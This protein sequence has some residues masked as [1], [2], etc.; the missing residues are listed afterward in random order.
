M[1]SQLVYLFDPETGIYTNYYVAQESPLEPG[2]FI[3]PVYSTP[4]VP[5]PAVQGKVPVFAGGAWSLVVDYR[6]QTWYDQTTGDPVQITAIGQPAA[7]LAATPLPPP[8]PTPTVAPPPPTAAQLL[9]QEIAAGEAAAQTLLN[10]GARSWGYDSLLSA[11]S[12]VTSQVPQFAA[13]AK[14][15][16]AWRDAL[17]PAAYAIETAVQAGTQTMPATAAAFVALL[18]QLPARPTA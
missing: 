13:D 11:A 17:W 4:L 6:G 5:L 3:E 2:V 15:L 9:A 14:A 7:N 16:I 10:T 1:A 12:Y 18:P 8:P